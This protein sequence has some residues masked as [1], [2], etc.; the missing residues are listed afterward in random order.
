[1]IE[2]FLSEYS[3]AR[4]DPR[5]YAKKGYDTDLLI[6]RSLFA[7]NP[8]T[9]L[10]ISTNF[11]LTTDGA[12]QLL[13]DRASV[14][15]STLTN[16]G[17]STIG[18]STGIVTASTVF[19]M[20]TQ[21][22]GRPHSL[23]VNNGVLYL[24]GNSAVTTNIQ[25]QIVSTVIGLGTIGYVSTPALLNLVSTANLVG[26]ISTPNLANL[27]STSFFNAAIGSTINGLGNSGYI[28]SQQ[29]ISTTG[30]VTNQLFSTSLGLYTFAAQ[31]TITQGIL[32][33]T[34]VG[35]G[36]IGYVSSPALVNLISTANV[37]NMVSTSY[38]E[39][40]LIS[41]VEGLGSAGY[42]SSSQLIS[43]TKSLLNSLYIVNAGNIYINGQG[44]T[45]SISTSQNIIYLSSILMSSITYSG[46][47]GSI[48]GTGATTPNNYLTF[49]SANLPLDQMSS[50]ITA[51]S[52]VT[53]DAYPSYLFNSL[54]LATGGIGLYMS[55]FI[56]GVGANYLSSQMSQSRF[57]VSNT[58]PNSNE[59]NQPIR[60]S[61]PGSVVQG[62]Y[63][64]APFTLGHYIPNAISYLTAQGFTSS[65]VNIFYSS[66]N[67]LFFS[68]Q[69]L[70]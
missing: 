18:L 16:K 21:I 49:T 59:F 68:I 40:K 12:G 5:F 35:L 11:L 63:G 30:G 56:K 55:T 50:Y 14:V 34:T 41:T 33:S 15:I 57:Y 1:M 61:V 66:T 46:T 27:V 70:A 64:N 25:N 53:I 19:L 62:F 29:L 10:P 13:W 65:N 42:V 24:D 2:R 69:N 44:V 36:S 31:A 38:F 43:T 3:S 22:P 54:G 7:L 37:L 26:L 39:S 28:S 4:M 67:S 20:D 60:F 23:T 6:L 32:T 58:S 17:I 51:N 52:R 47:N 45:L 8:T 48:L 9:N